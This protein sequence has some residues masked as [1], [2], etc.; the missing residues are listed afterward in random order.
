MT[1]H[2]TYATVD[3]EGVHVRYADHLDGGGSDFGRAY[4][5]FIASRFGKVPRLLEWCC[6]PAFI[7]F[8]LLGAGLCEQLDLSDVNEEAVAA[9]RETATANDLDDRVSVFHSDCFDD[10]PADRTWDL[11]V[12]NPPHMNVTTAPAEHIEVFRKIKP[13]LVYADKDWEIHRR[14]Y[15]QA[16]AR[17]APGGSVLLQECWAASDP[18]VFRPMIADAG[19][20]IAGVF[21]CE[22]PHELFYFL[23]VRAA[24]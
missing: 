20:E 7:G 9:A 22:A 21:P 15:G 17:L 13:E 12:G 18:E 23:W 8:S 6:G 2:G 10:V 16:A 19:L 11:I 1:I 5:P 4:V 24:A 14:F 3:C